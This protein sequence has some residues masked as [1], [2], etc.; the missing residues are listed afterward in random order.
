MFNTSS[1]F[2]RNF[3]IGGGVISITLLLD[4]DFLPTYYDNTFVA[5]LHMF[6][7]ATPLFAKP[8]QPSS[9]TFT[10]INKFKQIL[11]ILIFLFQDTIHSERQ[12]NMKTLL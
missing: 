11:N 9:F 2:G 5:C 7:Q 1:F 4:V 10:H 3:P 8:H 6:Y 12:K